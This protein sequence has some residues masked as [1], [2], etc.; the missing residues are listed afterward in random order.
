M[1]YTTIDEVVKDLQMEASLTEKVLNVL[2]DESLHAQSVA[3]EYWT[4]GKLAWHIAGG[5]QAFFNAAGLQFKGMEHDA[6]VPASAKAIADMYRTVASSAIAAIQSNWT[7]ATLKE[8]RNLWGVVE[9]SVPGVVNLTIRHQAHHRGQLTV[10]MRY[11]GLKAP[12]VYGPSQEESAAMKAG[13]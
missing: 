12:G 1:A 13:R 7:D 4:V 6:P 11:A 3:E 2:T 5:Y 8:T 9:L 10:L